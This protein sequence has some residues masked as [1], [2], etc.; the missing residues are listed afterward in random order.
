MNW[1]KYELLLESDFKIWKAF[2]KLEIADIIEIELLMKIFM[3]G[4][5]DPYR[6]QEYK[7]FVFLINKDSSMFNIHFQWNKYFESMIQNI[8]F[9]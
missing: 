9:W 3:I 7:V 1:I 2:P 6:D 8:D 4:C 5:F